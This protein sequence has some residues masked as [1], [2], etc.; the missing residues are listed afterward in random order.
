ME[1][2][3]DAFGPDAGGETVDRVVGKLDGFGGRA[4]GHGGQ[5]GAE[6]FLLGDDAG[7]MDVA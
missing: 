2:D 6:D 4:E 3:V 5:D 7:G 1:A